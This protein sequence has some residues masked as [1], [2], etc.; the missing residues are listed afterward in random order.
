MS[1]RIRP[2][3]RE[4]SRIVVTERPSSTPKA[5]VSGHSKVGAQDGGQR[6]VVELAL[7][8]AAQ[9]L[10]EA[11]GRI[12]R[13]DG[14]LRFAH[15]DLETALCQ[16]FEQR[17]TGREVAVDRPDSDTGQ[18][19]DPVHRQGGITALELLAG[20]LQHL[21][22]VP[23]RIRAQRRGGLGW[24][25]RRRLGRHGCARTTCP[26]RAMGSAAVTSSMTA[27]TGTLIAAAPSGVPIPASFRS[28]A[29]SVR[30]TP[31][32]IATTAM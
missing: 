26:L 20:G 27:A 1:G 29:A 17:L 18:V 28:W 24:R 12:G 6:D 15:Q 23:S 19:G 8:R 13:V 5:S 32:S 14:D 9:H 11:C 7:Q 2:H 10:L 4:R 25:R 16:R 30:T 21:P 31:G 22:P 3:A